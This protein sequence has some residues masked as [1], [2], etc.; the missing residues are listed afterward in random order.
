ME[1]RVCF[2]GFHKFESPLKKQGNIQ[3]MI[4]Q[5]Y[6]YNMCSTTTHPAQFWLAKPNAPAYKSTCTSRNCGGTLQ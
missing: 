4:S 6:R 5:G 2:V 3:V 1:E